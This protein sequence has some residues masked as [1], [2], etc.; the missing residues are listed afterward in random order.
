MESIENK[1]GIKLI[2]N[3]QDAK[4]WVEGSELDDNI[5]GSL[6]ILIRRFPTMNYQRWKEIRSSFGPAWLQSLRM[7]L[8][9]IYASG[10]VWMRF[11]RE[12]P[13]QDIHELPA[14]DIWYHYFL[15]YSPTSEYDA[16]YCDEHQLIFIGH[17]QE[18]DYFLAIKADDT[19]RRVYALHADHIY[20]NGS[21]QIL[22]T[23]EE[24]IGR[25]ANDAMK[26]AFDSYADMFGHIVGLKIGDKIISA[27]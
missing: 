11:D 13:F 7:V 18:E 2:G 23:G 16:V 25:I 8:D 26:I 19:D 9:G 10:P 6:L 14:D 3:S 5:K 22:D 20:S 21:E 17:W 1:F 12:D 15:S 27:E 4:S 24:P